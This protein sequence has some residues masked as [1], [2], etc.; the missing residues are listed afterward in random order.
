[1]SGRFYNKFGDSLARLRIA[2]RADLRQV[3]VAAGG[4]ANVRFLVTYVAAGEQSRGRL[5][6]YVPG[7]AGISH[8]FITDVGLVAVC[9]S[10][11]IW[12]GQK[13]IVGSRVKNGRHLPTFG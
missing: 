10:A 4:P 1:V 9:R 3:S 12:N 11:N 13:F 7:R 6:R 5:V 2:T 8:P